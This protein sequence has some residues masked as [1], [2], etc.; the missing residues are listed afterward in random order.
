MV[1]PLEYNSGLNLQEAE[2]RYRE[3]RDEFD[4]VKSHYSGLLGR[5]KR[6]LREED[7]K[8]LTDCIGVL[9]PL[10]MEASVQDQV[11]QVQSIED[12]SHYQIGQLSIEIMDYLANFKNTEVTRL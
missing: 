5:F 9:L 3:V 6:N 11:R 12:A 1:R 10:G 4:K 2:E 8:T 7:K